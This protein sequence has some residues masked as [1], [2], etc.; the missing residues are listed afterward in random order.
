MYLKNLRNS[1]RRKKFNAIIP[2]ES[3]TI[4]DLRYF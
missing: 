4:K 3:Y 2:S 1:E